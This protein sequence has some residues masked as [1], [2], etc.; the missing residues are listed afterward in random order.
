MDIGTIIKRYR[1]E[2]K[3]SL[4][5]FADKCGA[6][7]SY[8]AMLEA[9]KNSKTGEPI[10]PTISMLKKISVGLDISVNELIALCDDMPISLSATTGT[11]VDAVIKKMPPE[12]LQLEEG[13]REL[14]D[15]IRLMPPEMKAMYR[16]ALRAALKSQ[17]LI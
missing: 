6:S 8:I 13:D 9:K 2:H 15:L 7:H 14:L 3:I 4:R 10:V 16:E 17:G 12:E 1:T 11:Y 5:D